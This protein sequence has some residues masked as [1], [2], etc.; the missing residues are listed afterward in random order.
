MLF[1]FFPLSLSLA[2]SLLFFLANKCQ[3]EHRFSFFSSVT[4]FGVPHSCCFIATD[5]VVRDACGCRFVLLLFAFSQ[6]FF[7][8]FCRRSALCFLFHT[9]PGVFS[10]VVTWLAV[11]GGSGAVCVPFISYRASHPLLLQSY[12]TSFFGVMLLLSLRFVFFF[13][14]KGCVCM[15]SPLGATL[16]SRCCFLKEFL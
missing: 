7:F 12:Y 15:L 14:F 9:S 11:I 16:F 3:I 10:T 6:L 8:F 1:F 5:A 13:F 4:C 2:L